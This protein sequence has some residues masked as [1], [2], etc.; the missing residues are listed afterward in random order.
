MVDLEEAL[1][2]YT[3]AEVHINFRFTKDQLRELAEKIDLPGQ[4]YVPIGGTWTMRFYKAI[5]QQ[6]DFQKKG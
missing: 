6:S 2:R 1:S 3:E 4:V 5:F